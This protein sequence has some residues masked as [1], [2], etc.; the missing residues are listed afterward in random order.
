MWAP[1]R[2]QSWVYLQEA[3]GSSKVTIRWTNVPNIIS[4]DIEMKLHALI[5]VLVV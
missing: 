5:E 3:I 1:Q 2:G 4:F